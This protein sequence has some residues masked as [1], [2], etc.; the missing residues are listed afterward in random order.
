MRIVFVGTTSSIHFLIKQKEHFLINH[1]PP[2]PSKPV[3]ASFVFGTQFKIFWMKYPGLWLS[4]WL[5]S[6]KY[7]RHR[8][9]SPSAIS[10]SIWMLWRDENTFCTQRKYK[11]WLIQ[12][13]V[14]TVAGFWRI[15]AG[16]KLWTLFCVSCGTWFY[17][18]KNS[19]SVWRS[20]HRTAFAVC[21]WI[22]SK[23]QLRW[24]GGDKL[25][26]N[27]LFYPHSLPFIA[28][29]V[30]F[31]FSLFYFLFSIL[32]YFYFLSLSSYTHTAIPNIG[33]STTFTHLNDQKW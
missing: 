26:F 28:S 16:C 10:G 8:Q 33:V 21:Q 6:E 17:L 12:Q 23:I 24:R 25:M 13:F 15:T 3:K 7:E 30:H 5:H 14:V 9:N 18:N 27:L 1:L 19:V 2:C 4:H 31:L 20:W 22:F 32:F 11:L 29:F